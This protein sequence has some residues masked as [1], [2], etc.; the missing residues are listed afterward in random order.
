MIPELQLVS[1]SPPQQI[2]ILFLLKKAYRSSKM[3]CDGPS[4]IKER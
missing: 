2:A 1:F 3:A 4:F